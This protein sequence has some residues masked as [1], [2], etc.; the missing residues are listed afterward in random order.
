MRSSESNVATVRDGRR[1]VSLALGPRA[2]SAFAGAA[3][4]LLRCM[5]RS[6]V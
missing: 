1:M 4:T 2:T 6:G 5:A 3:L